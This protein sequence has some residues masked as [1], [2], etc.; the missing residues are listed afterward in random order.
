MSQTGSIWYFAYGSNMC[1]GKMC[2][3]IEGEW[4][5]EVVASMRGYEVI[6]NKKS[7][8]WGVA[9][10]ISKVPKKKCWGVLYKISSSQFG[11]LQSS[12]K[13]YEVMS[14]EVVARDGRRIKAK[15]FVA[16]PKWRTRPGR[17]RQEYLDFV[18]EGGVGHGLPNRYTRSLMRKAGEER[19]RKAI[20]HS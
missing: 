3:T 7:K 2:A 16:L 14:L 19:A 12:E 10:N 4:E 18:W 17:P 15:T 5:D 6:F 20:A 11:K 1:R 13:G 9:A 8:K